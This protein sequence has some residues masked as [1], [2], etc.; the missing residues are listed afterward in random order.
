MSNKVAWL[1][2]VATAFVPPALYALVNFYLWLFGNNVPDANKVFT[3]VGVG[4]TAGIVA[5]GWADLGE[6]WRHDERQNNRK[7]LNQLS[8]APTVVE[9]TKGE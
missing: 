6:V 8:E 9:D 2:F 3:S 5:A 1:L 4:L 7:A